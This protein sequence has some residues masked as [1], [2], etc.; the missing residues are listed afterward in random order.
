MSIY[1]EVVLPIALPKTFVYS[2]AQEL[3]SKVK[4]G[5]RVA[6]PFGKGKTQAGMILEIYSKAPEGIE[7]KDVF[8]LLDDY[9]IVTQTHIRFWKWISEYYM[10]TLGEVFRAALPSGMRLESEM[11]F[12][13]SKK[14]PLLDSL[15]QDETDIVDII[16]SREKVSLKDLLNL[17]EIKNP[18]KKI[19][20]LIQSKAIDLQERFGEIYKPLIKQF[21][22]F[23]ET[24]DS[25]ESALSP[26][27]SKLDNA[28]KQREL[29]L[30]FLSLRNQSQKPILV[31]EFLKTANASRA[32][33]QGL[34]KKGIFKIE[35]LQVDRTWSKNISGIEQLPDLSDSQTEVLKKI[36]LSIEKVKNCVLHGVT[37]SGKTE[38]FAHLILQQLNLGRQ[39][40]YLIPEIALTTQLISRFQAYFQHRLLVF[41]S[42]QSVHEKNRGMES[43]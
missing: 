13:V 18:L 15:S 35:K 27:F 28:P 9:P 24:Y 36:R 38:V 21:V 7:F 32:A 10:C 3:E 11:I 37:S 31:S 43:C 41:H 17:L 1:V 8:Y 39:V 4:I 34:V 5:L 14:P 26:I 33:L 25:D 19:N 30:H 16:E 6:V 42:R 29:L 12:S 2:I 20:R 22:S 23:T 40:L